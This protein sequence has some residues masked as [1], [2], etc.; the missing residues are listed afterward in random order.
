MLVD[1][2]PPADEVAG[3]D[4]PALGGRRGR[5]QGQDEQGHGEQGSGVAEHRESSQRAEGRD[6]PAP[7]EAHPHPGD[8]S[9]PI[10]CAAAPFSR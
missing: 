9:A 8:G 10:V 3:V 1:A 7:G 4:G 2:V 6:R 5:E